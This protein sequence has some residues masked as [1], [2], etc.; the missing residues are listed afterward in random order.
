[1]EVGLAGRMSMH[2]MEL[3]EPLIDSTVAID[4]GLGKLVIKIFIVSAPGPGQFLVFKRILIAFARAV[5]RTL[6]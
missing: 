3:H 5:V 1:M 2:F 4:E 6:S